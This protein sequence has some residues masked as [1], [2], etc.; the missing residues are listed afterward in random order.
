MLRGVQGRGYRVFRR[1]CMGC[2]REGVQGVEERVYR[3]FRR[4]CI[5]CLGEGV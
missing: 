2:L 1:E 4:G 3:V 5:G